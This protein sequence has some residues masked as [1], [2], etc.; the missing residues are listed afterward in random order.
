MNHIFLGFFFLNAY[1]PRFMIDPSSI[2]SENYFPHFFIFLF[3]SS[4]K[5]TYSLL[6]LYSTISFFYL[7]IL[8]NK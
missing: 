6:D 4:S 7:W 3:L 8:S 2:S 1:L 5:Y